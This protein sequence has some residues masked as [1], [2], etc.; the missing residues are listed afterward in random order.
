MHYLA[1]YGLF[2][3]QTITLII[4]IL[5]VILGIVAIAAKS[6]EKM[7]ERLEVKK[8]NHK[9]KDMKH[10]LSSVMLT[11]DDYK[12]LLKAEKKDDKKTHENKRKVFLINFNGDM[13]ASAVKHLRQEITAIL[14]VATAADEV[15]V[16][17]ESPGGLVHTYG[18]AASQ[19]ARIRQHQIPLTVIVDKVA[20]SGGYLMACVANQ[21]I[22][23]PF[24]IIGSIGV[25]AQLPN[26]HRLLE[27][28]N[29][30][31]ELMTAGEYKRTLTLF[32]KNT[33]K[34]REKFKEEIED[35]HRLFKRFIVANRPQVNIDEVATGE[36]WYGSEAIHLK[37]IDQIS[38]SDDYLL[39]ASETADIYKVC[40]IPKKTLSDKLS[41]TA[42][43]LFNSVLQHWQE[44]NKVN[45]L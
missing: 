32:G 23:A 35:V 27:K 41:F 33:E 17:L 24:A 5:A 36:H 42:S 31:Y 29:I 20:A 18:L 1:A 26:F 11:E 37:L 7:H 44:Q 43:K 19:L 15:I 12:K 39:K 16:C 40:Y 21:I 2:L 45:F 4:A 14:T 3:A 10:T 30:D 34:G 9:Y 28:H 22:A 38:T 13:R 25:V 6:K 8:L